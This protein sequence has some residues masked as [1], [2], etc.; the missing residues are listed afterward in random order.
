M[1][2]KEEIASTSYCQRKH[3]D[4][5]L[6]FS[7]SFIVFVQSSISIISR[8]RCFQYNDKKNI[9]ICTCTTCRQTVR[10]QM[11]S[12]VEHLAAQEKEIWR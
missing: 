6:S 4:I 5:L 11:E 7:F 10:D 1:D 9:Y 2:Q 8:C 12:K 3:F